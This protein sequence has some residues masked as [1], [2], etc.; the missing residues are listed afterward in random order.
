ML[1]HFQLHCNRWRA[2]IGLGRYSEALQDERTCC[3][4][5]SE[6]DD[7]HQMIMQALCLRI[8]S[9]ISLGFY[10]DAI[11]SWTT[12]YRLA[13]PERLNLSFLSIGKSVSNITALAKP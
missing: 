3:A 10:R 13:G 7:S 4:I 9:L 12:F 8:E 5:S 11:G 1:L 2:Y 6:L